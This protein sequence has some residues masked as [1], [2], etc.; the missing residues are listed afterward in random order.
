[1]IV[2]EADGN[3]ARIQ[4][5]TRIGVLIEDNQDI[6]APFVSDKQRG[7]GLGLHISSKL[8][9]DTMGQ[10]SGKTVLKVGLY[11]RFSSL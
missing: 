1:M 7:R 5:A 11:L 6:F 2:A 9:N 3:V 10:S 4:V 8:S